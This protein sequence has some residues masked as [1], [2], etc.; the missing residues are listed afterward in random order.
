MAYKKVRKDKHVKRTAKYLPIIGVFLLLFI[1]STVFWVFSAVFSPK[2][3]AKTGIRAYIANQ[4]DNTVSAIDTSTQ[5]VVS[6]FSVGTLPTGISV[7]SD[8]AKAYVSNTVSNTVSVYDVLNGSVT[9]TIPVG[10]GP[11]YS[12]IVGQYL[13]VPNAASNTIS[14]IDTQTDSVATTITGDSTPVFSVRSLDGSKVYVSHFTPETVSIIDTASNTVINS[15]SGL[16]SSPTAMTVSPDGSKLYAS[17]TNDNSISVIDTATNS[18][19]NVNVGVRVAGITVSVDGQKIYAT[20]DQGDSVSVID[21][22]TYSLLST[23]AVGDNPNQ[24]NLSPDGLEVYVLNVQSG[25][26]SVIDTQTDTVISTVTV[27]NGPNGIAFGVV[28]SS[29]GSLFSANRKYSN[30]P[31]SNITTTGNVIFGLTYKFQ[32][33]VPT[34]VK[35]FSMD[36]NAAN[37]HFNATTVSILSIADTIA[38]IKGSG[39]LNGNSGYNFLVTGID[40]GRI[41]I[42]ITD[43]SNNIVYDTQ[44]GD[45]DTATP[46]TSVTGHVVVN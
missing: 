20:N 32:N 46:T 44:S 30:P 36:F 31:T 13:Y 7:T 8:G 3:F 39:T 14:V 17:L 37:L 21:A 45:P 26:V 34:A 15:I 23:I 28:P 29:Q 16:G 19:N 42:K 27:G 18:I 4:Q 6:T 40:A 12:T 43:S 2:V 24:I 11:Q 41:R 35:E 25:T 10:S 9:S 33:G 1:V 5:T 22:I 38:T